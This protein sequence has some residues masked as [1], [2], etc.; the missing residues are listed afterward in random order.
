MRDKRLALALALILLAG[1]ALAGR[2]W[3]NVQRIFASTQLPAQRPSPAPGHGLILPL[4]ALGTVSALQTISVAAGP[5][6]IG[7]LDAHDGDLLQVGD[8]AYLYGTS[9]GCGFVWRAPSPFCGLRLYTSH[10]IHHW[11][12]RGLLFDPAVMQGFC[13]GPMG[14]FNPRVRRVDDGYRLWF[15]ILR[16][17]GKLARFRATSPLGP[18]QFDGYQPAAGN[19]DFTVWQEAGELWVFSTVRRQDIVITGPSGESRLGRVDVE[20]PGIFK[21]AGAYYLTVSDPN[22]GYCNGSRAALGK[23][24]RS[25]LSYYTASALPGP[26]TYGGRVLENAYDG[27]PRNVV[28]INQQ[29]YEWV[30]LWLGTFKEAA[31]A[32]RLQPL[33]VHADGRLTVK[34]A[35]PG[36]S[37]G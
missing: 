16:R 8:T 17:P 19:G 35:T 9:Y 30:D 2:N 31:A 10:D 18:W 7:G 26:W 5:I 4:S 32:I 36:T 28:L 12:D 23:H 11:R 14:C 3:P 33:A 15:N 13:D 27:Q 21:V 20:S 29:P 1:W 34:V 25:G 22:C 6:I 37:S 24:V